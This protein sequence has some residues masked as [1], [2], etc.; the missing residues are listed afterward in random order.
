M[1]CWG[2]P[3]TW[4]RTN[5]LCTIIREVHSHQA[6]D[7]AWRVAV[8]WEVAFIRES[9]LKNL[10]CILRW[11]WGF[12]ESVWWSTCGHKSQEYLFLLPFPAFI[13]CTVEHASLFKVNSTVQ[14]RPFFSSSQTTHT[15][16]AVCVD[17]SWWQN[18]CRLSLSWKGMWTN[19][20]IR[21]INIV[22]LCSPWNSK[23]P[24]EVLKVWPK[25]LVLE[26]QVFSWHFTLSF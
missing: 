16:I 3:G 6:L 11:R 17:I 25:R 15:F 18:S 4:L 20:C 23:L 21:W 1:Q 2:T 13:L 26:C 14:G 12:G 19:S 24:T 8:T 7:L 22:C 9:C 5:G 10:V